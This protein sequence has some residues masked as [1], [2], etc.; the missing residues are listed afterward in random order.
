[1]WDYLVDFRNVLTLGGATSF[2]LTMKVFKYFSIDP[3]LSAIFLTL[4]KA[5]RPLVAFFISFSLL[6]FAFAFMG[7][8]FFGPCL[9]EF[10]SL[11]FTINTLIRY[12]LGDFSYVNLET[13]NP[14]AA[15]PFFVTYMVCVFLICLNVAVAI[16]TLAYERVRGFVA[17]ARPPMV[18]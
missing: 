12:P 16:L 6:L 9:N 13:C 11:G 18:T 3:N 5:W 4:E 17:S 15:A 10:R 1:M 2:L 7:M 8:S 14:T